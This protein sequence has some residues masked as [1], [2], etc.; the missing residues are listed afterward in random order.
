MWKQNE[1]HFRRGDGEKNQKIIYEKQN[2]AKRLVIIMIQE[3]LPKWEKYRNRQASAK[4]RNIH[5]RSG[6]DGR[7]IV[8][9]GRAAEGRKAGKR[10]KGRSETERGLHAR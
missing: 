5:D 7:K 10:K 8:E 9:K 2:V 1:L 4:N 6:E 3:N